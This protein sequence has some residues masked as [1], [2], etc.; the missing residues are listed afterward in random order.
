MTGRMCGGVTTL[1]VFLDLGVSR[2]HLPA[3]CATARRTEITAQSAV[4]SLRR[5][6]VTSPQRKPHHA[7]IKISALNRASM[8]SASCPISGHVEDHA[9]P[10]WW[11]RWWRRGS[12][13]VK[14][15]VPVCDRSC[16]TARAARKP[17]H[18]MRGYRGWRLRARPV[19]RRS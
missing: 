14:R 13:G 18:D 12:G 11:R 15:Q 3:L 8:V 19:P 4:K 16:Y 5:S 9:L 2:M 6:S 10:A 7:L 17:A 1:R